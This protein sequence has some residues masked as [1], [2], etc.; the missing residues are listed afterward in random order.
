M[1]GADEATP[2][3]N[4]ATSS[5]LLAALF[6][7]GCH[8]YINENGLFPS[9]YYAKSYIG[10]YQYCL[11]NRCSW[12][13][14]G[15]TSLTKWLSLFIM[16]VTYSKQMTYSTEQRQKEKTKYCI[17]RSTGLLCLLGSWKRDDIVLANNIG[18]KIDEKDNLGVNTVWK[19]MRVCFQ[20][21]NQFSSQVKPKSLVNFVHVF[22]LK[23]FC[24]YLLVSDC[25][26]RLSV[27]LAI[28]HRD[29]LITVTTNNCNSQS[30]TCQL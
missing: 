30:L 8:L 11:P 24:M 26:T 19:E 5:Q 23:P 18:L 15:N 12:S 10:K 22:P 4:L 29:D 6:H 17:I 3:G 2:F 1:H 28:G 14:F 21:S 13:C 7:F 20:F 27:S 16:P 25:C 9:S